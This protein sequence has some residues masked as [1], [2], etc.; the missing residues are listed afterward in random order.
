MDERLPPRHG[1]R[2]GPANFREAAGLIGVEPN[3]R[4]A[5]IER[6]PGGG[7][8]VDKWLCLEVLWSREKPRFSA[9]CANGGGIGVVG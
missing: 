7:S 2:A 8:T 3:G 9:P 4:I 6:A 1:P 5:L